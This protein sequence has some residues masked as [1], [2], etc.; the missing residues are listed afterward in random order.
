M[1]RQ[2]IAWTDSPSKPFCSERCKLKDLATWSSD[3][4]KVSVG[5]ELESEEGYE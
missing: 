3:T 2:P 5:Y 1:C 4:Y